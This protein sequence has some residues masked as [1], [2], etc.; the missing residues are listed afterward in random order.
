MLEDDSQNG[1]DHVDAT[2]SL[3]YVISP[4]AKRKTLV[5]SNYNTVSMLRTMEDLLGIG[6]LGINDANTQPMSD[7]FTKN[8]DFTPY[9]AIVPGNLCQA[10]V[11]TNLVP[12]CLDP[13]VVKTTAMPILRDKQWWAQ[14]TKDFYFDVED[15]LDSEAF[16]RVLWAGIKGDD[17]PY[18]TARSHADL[19]QNRS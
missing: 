2:R 15:K 3:A 19:R 7:A 9:T 11:D 16:N 8:P 5:S 4:Y 6:Y 13:D 17:V 1:P 12:A 14:A 10:P 18:P